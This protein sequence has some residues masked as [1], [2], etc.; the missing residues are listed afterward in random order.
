M[1]MTSKETM[2]VV[3]PV[4]NRPELIRRCLDS[5]EAQTWRPLHVIVV[6]NAST[7]DTVSSVA[8][9]KE[10]HG[11]DGF[12]LTILSESRKGAAYARQTGL[13]RV[14]TD[15]VMFFDSDDSMRPDCVASVME[16]W[17]RDPDADIVAWPVAKHVGNGKVLESRAVKGNILE[18]HMVHALFQTLAYAVKTDCLRKAGGWRGEFPNWNDL[19]TGTRLLLGNPSVIALP[20]PLVD[21]YPQEESITGTSYSAKNGL[22]EMSLDGMERSIRRS[23]RPDMARLLAIVSYRRAILAA[24]YAKEGRMDLAS[25]LYERS[26][27]EVPAGKRPL[28]RFAYHWTRCRMRGAFSIVGRFL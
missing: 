14:A 12:S 17:R 3:V 8:R 24:T 23:G 6:D 18:M 10:T 25:P 9:W 2:T 19:E 4:F 27:L 15:K 21:V 20:R 1:T 26:L 13:D 11:S 16:A 28:I 22:W 7:D 5:I